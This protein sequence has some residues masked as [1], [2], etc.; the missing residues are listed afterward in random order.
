MVVH[1]FARL[2]YLHKHNFFY[3]TR[4]KRVI[5]T[6]GKKNEQDEREKRSNDDNHY[7]SAGITH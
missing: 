6:F 1:H 5:I 3:L 4:L 7:G 2:L